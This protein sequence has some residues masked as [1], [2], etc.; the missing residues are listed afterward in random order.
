MAH[1]GE[2]KEQTTTQSVVRRNAAGLLHN[3]SIAVL[4]SGTEL[5]ASYG[6]TYDWGRRGFFFWAIRVDIWGVVGLNIGRN[7]TLNTS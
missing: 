2:K 7:V 1:A 4:S 6:S 5:G 3:L